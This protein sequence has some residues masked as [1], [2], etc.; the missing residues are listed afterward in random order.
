LLLFDCSNC[1]DLNIF[2]KKIQRQEENKRFRVSCSMNLAGMHAPRRKR[3]KYDTFGINM[4][5][6]DA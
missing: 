4:D 6:K 2:G 3:N 5:Y 1:T